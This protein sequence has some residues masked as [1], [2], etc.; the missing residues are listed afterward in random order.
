[1][2]TTQQSTGWGASLLSLLGKGIDTAGAIA[3]QKLTAQY[4]QAT[5][6]QQ[7]PAAQPVAQPAPAASRVPSWLPIAGIA[8]AGLLVLG[9]VVKLVR[10]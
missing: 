7:A 3:Q 6:Q 4:A 1:V 8:L 5:Q 2:E 9:I 10:R